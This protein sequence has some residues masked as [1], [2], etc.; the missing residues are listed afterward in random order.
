M[1]GE[2]PERACKNDAPEEGSNSISSLVILRNLTV[3]IARL[4]WSF[5]T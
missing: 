3:A 1:V 4:R 2:R 5:L